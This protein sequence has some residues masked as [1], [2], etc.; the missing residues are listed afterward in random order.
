M[1]KGKIFKI[2]NKQIDDAFSVHLL[3]GGY[4]AYI[5]RYM[6]LSRLLDFIDNNLLTFVSPE[7]WDD[8][9]ELLYYNADYTQIA[10]FQKPQSLYCLCVRNSNENEEASWKAYASS[11]EPIVKIIIEFSK[12][13]E[14]LSKNSKSYDIYAG[15]VKY[16]EHGTNIVRLHE[17][18]EY[19][20]EY[21]ADFNIES[22]IKLM[23]VKRLAFKYEDEWRF[24]AIPKSNVETEN[25]L[26]KLNIDSSIIRQITLEPQLRNTEAEDKLYQAKCRAIKKMIKQRI[27]NMKVVR[28][29]LY[30]KIHEI[31][32]VKS[33]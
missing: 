1:R 2:S 21:F 30:D 13:L 5:E 4:K 20:Q 11:N 24:F 7:M 14:E 32:T 26:V 6:P 31:I 28:S 25:K 23:C 9:F 15:K 8:P 22:Y 27:P 17:S 10:N 3:N 29:S 12:L 33:L 16:V 19:R 18:N